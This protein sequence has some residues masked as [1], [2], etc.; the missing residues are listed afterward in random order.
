MGPARHG[1]TRIRSP[2]A[3]RARTLSITNGGTVTSQVHNIIGRDPGSTGVVNVEGI[4]STYT[5]VDN[6]GIGYFG[7]GRLGIRDGAFVS[8]GWGELGFSTGTGVATVTG[9][10]S[11]LSSGPGFRVGSDGGSGTLSVVGGGAVTVAGLFWINEQGNSPEAM[12]AVDVGTG[13]SISVT[14]NPNYGSQFIF[15]AGTSW[16]PRRSWPF[17]FFNICAGAP[18]IRENGTGSTSP[19]SR[20]KRWSSPCRLS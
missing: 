19:F 16:L 2:S 20:R 8:C 15:A 6:L 14:N 3:I 4:G 11:T 7:N 1:T 5:C 18:S 17:S 12:L 10:G 13:S 9:A